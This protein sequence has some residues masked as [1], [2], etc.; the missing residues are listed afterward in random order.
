M[1]ELSDSLL[2]KN[3]I[4]NPNLKKILVVEDDLKN[5]KLFIAILKMIPNIQ[6]ISEEKGDRAVDLIKNE[7]PDLIILDIQLP[8]KSGI[9]ICKELRMLEAFKT[10]PLIAVTAFA[11]KGDKERILDAGFTSY[12]SKPINIQNFKELINNFLK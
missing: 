7:K 1:L 11:M 3:L 10:L 8:G 9:E 12:I 4:V 6:I 5:M 2:N